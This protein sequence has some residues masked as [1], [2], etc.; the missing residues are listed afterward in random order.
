MRHFCCLR[1]FAVSSIWEISF[2]MIT[3]FMVLKS[4]YRHQISINF[5]DNRILDSQN[6][7]NFV[8]TFSSP[9]G[10]VPMRVLG[11]EYIH[12]FSHSL[13][14]HP[15][16]SIQFSR[17]VVSNSLGPHGLKHARLCCLSPTPKAYPNSRPL[18]R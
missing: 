16:S 17:S 11:L 18:S 6:E 14:A 2:L 13:I 4:L 15:F 10:K 9:A 3:F 12:S 8:G 7:R 1:S 5:I